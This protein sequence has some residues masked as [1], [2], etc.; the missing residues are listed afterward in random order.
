MSG[1]SCPTLRFKSP[2]VAVALGFIL[3]GPFDPEIADAAG[4]LSP[5]PDTLDLRQPMALAAAAIPPR[6]DPE[7]GYRPWFLLRGR[8]GIPVEPVHAS[9]DLADMTGR[10]LESLILARHMGVSAPELSEAEGR[11]EHFL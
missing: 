11:L 1:C 8:G 5:A 9:W 6:L 10:Y 2:S 4:S 3:V 7:M